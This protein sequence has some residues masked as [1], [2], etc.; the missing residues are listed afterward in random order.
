MHVIIDY[1]LYI[2]EDIFRCILW[3]AY[4]RDT[5]RNDGK[6]LT[7]KLF[8]KLLDSTD[9]SVTDNTKNTCTTDL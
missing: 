5:F 3:L 7:V 2:F 9:H 4:L 1:I 8:K 6:F